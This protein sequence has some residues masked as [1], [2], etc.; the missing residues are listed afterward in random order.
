MVKFSVIITGWNCEKFVKKCLDSIKEQTVK[1]FDVIIIDDGSTDNTYQ[2]MVKNAPHLATILKLPKNLGTYYARDKA[3][4]ESKGDIIVMIDCDD[5]LLPNALELCKKQYL[6]GNLMT[7]GNYQFLN[8]KICPVELEYPDEIKKTRDYRKDTFRCTHLRTFKKELYLSI[9]KW[10]LTESE[11]NSY[12][13]VEILF[14]MME[15]CGPERIAC[16]KTPIYVYNTAN[17]ESTLKRF[18]KD[19]PGYYEICNRQKRELLPLNF[20]R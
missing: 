16:I 10:E 18:G 7:Y 5:Y 2:E 1:P 19:Y 8:G 11:I 3:I 13:D 6:K 17:P 12:P 20:I 14:S 15:M 4:N 9:P